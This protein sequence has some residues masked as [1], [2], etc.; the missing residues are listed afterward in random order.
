MCFP[1]GDQSGVAGVEAG[2]CQG[3]RVDPSMLAM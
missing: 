3:V 2:S 1:S